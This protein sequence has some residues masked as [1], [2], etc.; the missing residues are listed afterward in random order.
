MPK[1]AATKAKLPEA[2]SP[3]DPSSRVLTARQATHLAGVS[4]VAVETLAGK[5]HGDLEEILRHR[6]DPLLL[7]YRKICGRVVRWNPATQL[8]EGVPN[9]TV[10][11]EDTDCWFLGFFPVENPWWWLWPFHCSREDI[12]SVRTDECGNFCVLVPRWD[13]D[14]VLRLRKERVCYPE[15]VRPSLG[16]LIERLAPHVQLPKRPPIGPDPGPIELLPFIGRDR[17]QSLLR[18]F[19][20]EAA[21]T[22]LA[23]GLSERRFGASTGAATRMLDQPAFPQTLPP[24][25]PEELAEKL[26]HLAGRHGLDEKVHESI[27]PHQFVGPFLRCHDVLV[28][29]WEP[30]IDVPD[31]TFRV[32]QDIDFDGDE[33]LIY[34]EGYFDV[35]WNA[36]AIPDVTLVASP[37][38]LSVPRCDGPGEGRAC[39]DKPEIY[40]VGYLTLEDPSYH[41]P[42]T[43]FAQRPNRPH[44]LG[45][46][47]SPPS[48]P[49][50]APYRGSLAVHACHRL[51]GGVYYRVLYSYEGGAEQPFVGLTW[52]AGNRPL[53][54]PPP[55]TLFA[56]DPQGWYP[57]QAEAELTMPDWVLEWPT[58][59]F[60]D[61][62]YVL[63]VEVADGSKST[64]A[65]SDPMALAVDNQVPSILVNTFAWS[66]PVSGSQNLLGPCPV[67]HRKAGESGTI[68]VNWTASAP[69]FRNVLVGAGGC[70]EGD[71]TRTGPVSDYDHWYTGFADNAASRTSTFSLPG[72]LGGLPDGVYD[73]VVTAYSRHFTPDDSGATIVDWFVDQ[74]W[75]YSQVN[76][77]VAVVTDP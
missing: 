55:V 59:N 44:P 77:L 37:A 1:R 12:A 74:G 33:E 73:F 58:T 14:R 18:Q 26:A 28:A 61:G 38:A 52:Y 4:G 2:S 5:T 29:E 53:F 65:F 23:A 41:D 25:L 48:T 20:G 35:R 75:P 8:Y 71:P 63:R 15:I 3:P 50:Q 69:H 56:P 9:A 40:Q 7:F 60:A 43:G 16:D 72:G 39:T 67:V 31:I 11:V 22:Q 36:G 21:A 17:V 24:P 19:T 54:S 66:G 62:T 49:S 51:P 57:I 32:T 64:I 68:T 6:I 47:S 27:L 13:I 34:S 46:S 70:G 42:V 30:I 10:T 76:L 45:L